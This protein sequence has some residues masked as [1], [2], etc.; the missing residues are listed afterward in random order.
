MRIKISGKRLTA[1]V[2]IAMT[3]AVAASALQVVPAAAATVPVTFDSSTP[4]VIVSGLKKGDVVDFTLVLTSTDPNESGEGEPAQLSSTGGYSA[5]TANYGVP[6]SGSFTA[7]SDGETLTGSI[8]GADGDESATVQVAL[9]P[10]ANS[11]A[12]TKAKNA[13]AELSDTLGYTAG[14]F[15]IAAALLTELPPA[16]AL[17]GVLAGLSGI[18]AV[19]ANQIARDP[20]DP[21]YTRLPRPVVHRVPA[22]PTRLTVRERLAY[23]ELGA[24]LLRQ[25]ALANAAW[26]SYNRAAGATQAGNKFWARVQYDLAVSYVHQLGWTTMAQP[27]LQVNF[28]HA[29]QAAGVPDV[30]ITAA[31][32]LSW[33]TGIG[34]NGLP[35]SELRL[36]HGLGA[37]TEDIQI[38]TELELTLDTSK[39]GGTTLFTHLTDPAALA[40][41]RTQAKALI[42]A[43]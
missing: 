8:P 12:S 29:L 33:E 32:A 41:L 21:N 6:Y 7:Q 28:V 13:A 42:T 10:A 34:A 2:A 23:E 39:L 27:R 22:P 26:T 17:T 14:G 20:I 1:G 35:S 18:G 16:A 19:K 3:S 11:K 43:R 24:N 37:S 9:N 30:S 15:A 40:T 25:S 31:Q 5:V 38:L 36:L 4:T